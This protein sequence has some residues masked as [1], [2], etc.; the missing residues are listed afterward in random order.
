MWQG[1]SSLDFRGGQT[2]G[3]EILTDNCFFKLGIKP[4]VFTMTPAGL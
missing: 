1:E 2:E 4:K 3:G